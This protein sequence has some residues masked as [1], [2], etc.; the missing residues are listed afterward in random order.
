MSDILRRKVFV[1]NS[2]WQLINEVTVED[3]IK[4]MFIDAATALDFR[5]DDEY[6]PVKWEDWIKLE[7][8][9]AEETLHTTVSRIRMPTVIVA[10]N[11][12]RVPKRSAKVNLKTISERDGG[13][14]YV[15]GEILAPEDRSLD[16]LDPI[17]RGGSR[18]DPNNIALLHKK[19]NNKKG[20]KTPEEMGWKRPKLKK[21]K[22]FN[23]KPMHKHH[24]AIL[25]VVPVV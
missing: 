25:K 14:D 24:H 11:Y 21:L 6:Y 19:R 2:N 7:P 23:P 9:S 1:L 10:V 13:R 22:A 16:H 8:L 18:K 5:N 15:T 12:D 17:S 20:S 4:Q 3:A